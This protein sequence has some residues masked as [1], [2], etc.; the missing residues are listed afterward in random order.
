[1][2]FNKED[3]TTAHA[4]DDCSKARARA[5]SDRAHPYLTTFTSSWYTLVT[6]WV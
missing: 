6:S 4:D 1:M 5:H 2:L 3:Q